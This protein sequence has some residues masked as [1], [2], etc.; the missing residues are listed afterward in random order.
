MLKNDGERQVAPTLSGIRRDHVA[1]Y[2]W[3]AS[4]LD[5]LRVIDCGCGIGY[6]SKILADAG[7]WVGSY[8]KDRQALEYGNSNYPHNNVSRYCLDLEVIPG[9]FPDTDAA[10]AF[11]IIEHLKDPRPMLKTLAGSCPL[12]LASVPNEEVFPW[13]GYAFHYRHYTREQFEQLL[14]ECGWTVVKWYGQEG[15]ESEVEPD[16]NGRTLIVKAVRTADVSIDAVMESYAQPVPKHV[17]ILGLGPSVNQFTDICKSLGGRQQYCDEVWAINALGNVIACDRIFHMDDVRIQQ[18]RA[19][20][21]PESN[22]AAMLAWMKNTSTPIITSRTHPDYPSLVEFPLED[23]LDALQFDYFNSTAAYA[24]AYAI[25]LGVEKI[26]L[27]GCDYTYPNAHDAEKGRACL[28]FWLG[29][30]AARGIKIGL[31]KRT[32]LMDALYSRQERLYG[33]D[34]RTVTIDHDAEGRL[35]VMFSEVEQLPT[36]DEIEAAYDHT[37]HP[38]ALVAKGQNDERPD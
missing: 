5:N 7:K 38:N 1:R 29:Q 18:I 13:Q 8:D 15:P 12:L 19:E 3:A 26:S 34:T 27:F 11:E 14:N 31:P 16:V 36:A 35:H 10:V 37:Q 28:E 32:T 23:V 22:I 9:R 25:W 21:R 30:A 4:I 20:A 24:V 33:Y 17:A 6:G 2:E